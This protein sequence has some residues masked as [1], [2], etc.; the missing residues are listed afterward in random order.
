MND[1]LLT[2]ITSVTDQVQQVENSTC[3]ALGINDGKNQ[4]NSQLYD[5][6]TDRNEDQDVMGRN[7]PNSQHNPIDSSTPTTMGINSDKAS[8]NKHLLD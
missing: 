8:S 2:P 4:N 7:L 1:L 5:S 3:P 6:E